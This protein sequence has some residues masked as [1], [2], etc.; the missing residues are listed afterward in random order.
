MLRRMCKTLICS[1]MKSL[2]LFVGLLMVALGLVAIAAPDFLVT[3]GMRAITPVG[4]YVVAAIRIAIG[5]VLLGAASVSRMPRTL[6]VFGI[7]AIAAGVA[8]AFFG[9]ERAHAFMDWLSSAAPMA[10]RLMG[11][12]A[13]AIG[14]F[15][16]YAVSGR[17]AF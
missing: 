12:V 11:A 4:L 2:A 14:S 15:I 16:I 17:R 5:L 3:M 9:V 13:L 6:R 1:P 8:T 7:V 10:P